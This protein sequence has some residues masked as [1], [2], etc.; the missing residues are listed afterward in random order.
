M[1]TNRAQLAEQRILDALKGSRFRRHRVQ[2]RIY[3][4]DTR[5]D[6]DAAGVQLD[7]HH[8]T[9]LRVTPGP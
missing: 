5:L 8:R 2:R 3:E 7:R 4:R 6:V 9:E 1:T